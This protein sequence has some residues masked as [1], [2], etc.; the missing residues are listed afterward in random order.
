MAKSLEELRRLMRKAEAEGI[1]MSEL[2]R[3]GGL[4]AARMKKKEKEKNSKAVQLELPLKVEK[5]FKNFY[6]KG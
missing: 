2:G 3:R 1:T 5:S 4:K 6:A